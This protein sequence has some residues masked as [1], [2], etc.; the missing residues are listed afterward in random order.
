MTSAVKW[1]L[2]ILLPLFVTVPCWSARAAG[3]AGYFDVT[4]QGAT[5]TCDHD[6]TGAIQ[7]TIALALHAGLR[8]AGGGVVYLPRPSCAYVITAP[9]VL[10]SNVTLLGASEAGRIGGSTIRAGAAMTAMIATPANQGSAIALENITLDGGH[11]SGFTVTSAMDFLDLIGSRLAKC[12]N[13]EC[14]RE[15]ALHPPDG[16][17]RG[18]VDRLLRKSRHPSRQPGLLC[19]RHR[20]VELLLGRYRDRRGPWNS[21][22]G[23]VARD[24]E[25][26]V[27]ASTNRFQNL[28]LDPG[29]Q[30]DY[31]YF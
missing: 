23:G 27:V 20:G 22:S 9:L 12:L 21:S 3:N 13:R 14:R 24:R 11:S 8:G 10:G 5:G 4:V 1:M 25:C 18:D 6:D 16:H 7:K 28:D 31:Y 15:R 19:H 29:I 2:S 26:R 30:L 17:R